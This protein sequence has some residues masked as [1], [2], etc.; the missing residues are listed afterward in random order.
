M[1]AFFP[2]CNFSCFYLLLYGLFSVSTNLDRYRVQLCPNHKHHKG[3]RV[4]EL[5][6][7]VRNCG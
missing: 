5:L 2:V 4:S 7:S 6:D 1:C 3:F